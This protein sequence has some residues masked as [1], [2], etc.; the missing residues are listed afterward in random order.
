MAVRFGNFTY[1]ACCVLA[2]LWV[3][4]SLWLS[5]G[6]TWDTAFFVAVL[7]GAFAI[8]AIGRMAR[9]VLVEH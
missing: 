3:F 7:V 9:Y 5:D 6:T 8:W 4:M 1:S 2:I